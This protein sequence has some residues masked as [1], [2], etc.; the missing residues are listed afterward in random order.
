M[1]LMAVSAAL[2]T[3]ACSTSSVPEA[4]T[5]MDG[6]RQ[7]TSDEHGATTAFGV[8][9]DPDHTDR[10]IEIAA[11]DTLRFDPD[12]IQ[13]P[14][15]TVVTFRVR[16]ASAPHDFTVGDQATQD[17]HEGE[18]ASG[19]MMTHQE[20]FATHVPADETAELTWKFTVA[21]TF[22]FACHIPGHYGAGMRGEITVS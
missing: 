16:G 2:L 3:T 22:E 10:V 14:V 11:L 6:H 20:N 9:G 1:T 19:G 4:A 13:I 21:G 5:A 15:G 17:E 18:M 7:T 12:A 8:P